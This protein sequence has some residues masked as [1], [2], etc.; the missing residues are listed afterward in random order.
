[1]SHMQLYLDGKQEILSYLNQ[2]KSLTKNHYYL[3]PEQRTKVLKKLSDDQ[4]HALH[5]SANY[6]HRSIIGNHLAKHK[7]TQEWDFYMIYDHGERNEFARCECGHSLR[8]EFVLKNRVSGKLR[9]LGIDHFKQEL[10]IPDEIADAI[11]KN[12]HEINYDL[13]EI[14]SKF[15]NH[16]ELPCLYEGDH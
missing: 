1:M 10:G 12:L 16:W 5:F 15:I 13:D 2:R 14:L 3:S 7:G 11:N 4:K 6:S 9:S 8:Y